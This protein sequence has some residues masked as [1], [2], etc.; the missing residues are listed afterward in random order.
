VEE[1]H[2]KKDVPDNR[3]VIVWRSDVPVPEMKKNAR[4]VET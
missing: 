4:H 2:F 3:L 1:I